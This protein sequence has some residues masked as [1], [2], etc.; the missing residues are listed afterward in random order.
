MTQNRSRDK[1]IMTWV[2]AEERAQ[3]KEN[4]AAFG[5][6]LSDFVRHVTLGPVVENPRR[7]KRVPAQR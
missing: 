2:T 7:A 1:S 3:V 4:A 5:M 6:S